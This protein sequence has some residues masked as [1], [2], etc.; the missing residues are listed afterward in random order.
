M[1]ERIIK[2]IGENDFNK[3]KNKKVL[4]V[5]LGGVGGYAFETLIRSGINNIDIVDFDKIDISNL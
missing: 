5:G 2:L 3:I 4:I 1:Y